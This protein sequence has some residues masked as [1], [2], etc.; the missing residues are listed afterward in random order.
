MEDG[1]RNILRAALSAKPVRS[2]SLV[3]SI[4][5]RVEPLGGN[6][7]DLLTRE[8]M[9]EPVELKSSI[10]GRL[11]LQG[12]RILASGLG[13]MFVPKGLISLAIH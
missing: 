7:L 13:Y 10:P 12:L 1:A 2:A 8:P 6:E 5:A 4:R 3:D 9:R 11:K